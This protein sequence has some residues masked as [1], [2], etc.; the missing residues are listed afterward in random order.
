MKARLG[1]LQARLD[2][3]ERRRVQQ[4]TPDNSDSSSSSN[5]GCGHSY[6][7]STASAANN[8]GS[9]ADHSPITN[10]YGGEPSPSPIPGDKL[11]A[12]M[13][14]LQPNMYEQPMDETDPSLY[15]QAANF[16]N[17]PPNSHPSPP[18]AHGLLSP[19]GRPGA[20]RSVKVSEEFVLDCLRFQTQLLNRLNNLQQDP[21]CVGPPPYGAPD[22]MGP[23]TCAGLV[24]RGFS[25]LTDQF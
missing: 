19:P 1:E 3:H 21:S 16:L 7:T 20:E 4:A 6:D 8:G 18:P 12:P 15:H 9:V 2:S 24:I 13:P 5:A 11:P 22:G 17:S 10:G 14:M 23:S 25:R